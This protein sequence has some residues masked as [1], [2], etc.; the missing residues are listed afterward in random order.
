[1][2]RPL[3]KVTFASLGKVYELYAR[4]VASGELWGFVEVS[5]LEF[6]VRDGVV[7]D[8]AEDQ[9]RAEFANTR[10]LHLPVSS[11]LR[12]EEVLQKGPSVVRDA[13]TG[14]AVVTA[15]PLPLKPR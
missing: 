5:E 8:P 7:V 15:F 2:A 12:V 1:M 6:D 13:R 9:L 10:A 11:V 3:F 4:R 14:D